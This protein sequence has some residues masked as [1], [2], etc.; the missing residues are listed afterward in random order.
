MGAQNATQGQVRILYM[1]HRIP[2]EQAGMLSAPADACQ[3]GIMLCTRS[4]AGLGR[5]VTRS[6]MRG[7]P[8][9]DG[10]AAGCA[11]ARGSLRDLEAVQD[12][13][14]GRHADLRLDSALH[15]QSLRQ[16]AS[17]L[18]SP[19]AYFRL[20]KCFH[21]SVETACIPQCM[22]VDACS[23]PRHFQPCSLAAVVWRWHAEACAG[24]ARRALGRTAAAGWLES[25]EAPALTRGSSVQ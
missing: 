6:R 4:P 3:H 25:M 21:V 23:G 7:A 5:L 11:V 10:Q 1:Y 19:P 20:S 14:W 16:V 18:Y 15:G 12:G 17:L 2:L 8:V 24:A 13:R 9:D 22:H